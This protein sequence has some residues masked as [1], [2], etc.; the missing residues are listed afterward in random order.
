VL[1]Y[2]ADPA[3]AVQV[4]WESEL[5]SFHDSRHIEHDLSA[6]DGDWR[7]VVL[8]FS[9]QSRLKTLRLDSSDWKEQRFEIDSIV[10]RE[11]D[12]AEVVTHIIT[13]ALERLTKEIAADSLSAA[14][15]AARG[16]FFAQCGRWREAAHDYD[17][18]RELDPGDR[19]MWFK[20]ATSLVL[21]GEIE[22]YQ[23]TSLGMLKQF[24]QTAS[25]AVAR[26][27]CKTCLLHAIDIDLSE[28]PIAFVRQATELGQVRQWGVGTCALIAYREGDYAQALAWTK[29]E[30][31]TEPISESLNLIVRAMAE[32]QLGQHDQARQSLA[33][34]EA[35]MPVELQTLG[36]DTYAGPL[37]V[38]ME[39]IHHDWLAAE[40]LR[41]E[42]ASL[43]GATQAD[44]R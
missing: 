30:A 9:T 41:R 33:Q 17:R 29:Q 37:P 8:A 20:T 13:P 23:Q 36:A 31:K 16:M 25:D 26:S 35:L 2:R 34:A 27:L 44:E 38:A 39:L 40:I 18:A 32:Y 10:V 19:I 21:A 28:L 15:H 24:Q 42:A 5:E 6:A 4:Y 22:R 11:L 7:E 12:G 3:F 43:I 14:K 1:R